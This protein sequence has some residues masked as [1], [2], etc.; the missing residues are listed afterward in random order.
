MSTP[1]V[2]VHE[3]VVGDGTSTR[4][5][6]ARR[7]RRSRWWLGLLALA[8]VAALLSA[9]PEPPTSTLTLAP[10]NPGDLGARAAAQ[11]LG[12]EG[13]D[14]R[15][16]RHIADVEKL[17]VPDST[18][19]VVGDYLLS[20]TQVEALGATDADLVLVDAG[21]ALG[22]LSP[23]LASSGGSAAEPEIRAAACDDPD[24]VAAGTIT[25]RGGLLA[26]GPGAVVC[27]PEPGSPTDQGG[28][29]AV[30]ESDGRRIVALADMAPLT[31]QH[32]A[33]QG[34][35]ALVL[36]ALGRHERLVWYIPSLDD[37]G[38]GG[39]AGA[40]PA[41][42][43]PPVVPILALQLLLVVAGR[44]AVARTPA[45]PPRH[46]E[47]AGGRA[48]GRDDPGSRP[49]L[50]ARTVLRARRRRA[51]RRDGRTQRGSARPAPVRGGAARGRRDRSRG[52]AP[53]GGRRG[54]AVR[55]PTYRRPR[56]GSAGS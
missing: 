25:A 28:A 44:R 24:A 9:L 37:M 55:T 48:L 31:N 41:Q 51:A 50:P 54:A 52:R 23:S 47:A 20:D 7:W 56:A 8:V 13:V 6:S 49:P 11:I 4:S 34:N 35:A 27:F 22:T 29:Y 45:G 30:A 36:R 42:L 15:Y 43:L 18:V 16:V 5:R 53:S 40:A 17:A 26:I 10:D 46:R 38:T 33:E 39:D 12:R 19:L 21:W 2:T 3:A 14:V 1:V 32:L